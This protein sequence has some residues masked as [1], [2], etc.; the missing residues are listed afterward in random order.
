M[1]DP[2]QQRAV[3]A[4]FAPPPPLWKHFTRENRN[5]LE[6]FK[7]E[8]SKGPNGEPVRDKKWSPSELRALDVPSELRFLV[9]PE[10]PTGE[11]S[12]FGELQTVSL[13]K[14]TPLQ[15][16]DPANNALDLLVI[17]DS[18]FAARTR[19]R[20]ALP[21]TRG[22]DQPRERQFA[23]LPTPQPRLLSSEDQQVFAPQLP[24][25]CRGSLGFPRTIRIESQRFAQ[26][27]HQRSPPPQS[28]PPTPGSGVLDHDDGEA[29]ST[30][31]G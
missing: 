12:V 22:R 1:A 28:L 29:A 5:K 2:S 27:I 11:Y 13:T 23:T 18:P 17:Y 26:P 6:E 21:R 4:A 15:L 16:V 31:Q 19:H 30:Q 24:R 3:T 14:G 10:I 25:V 9:P 8:A 20:S 7:K